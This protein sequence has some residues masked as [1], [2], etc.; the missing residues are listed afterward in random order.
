MLV[1]LDVQ[2]DRERNELYSA[3]RLP[4][5]AWG[6][7]ERDYT[8]DDRYA[9]AMAEL[10]N[11][12]DV[13]SSTSRRASQPGRR[14]AISRTIITSARSAIVAWRKRSRRR[15]AP[16]ARGS[17]WP[18]RPAQA[19]ATPPGD[20]YLEPDCQRSRSPRWLD[21]SHRM[22]RRTTHAAVVSPRPEER[23][24]AVVVLTSA[25]PSGPGCG[26]DMVLVRRWRELAR[27]ADV[28]AI[29]PTPWAP[30]ALARVSRR[31]AA[32][33]AIAPISQIDGLT[34][35]HPR[36]LQLPLPAFAPWAG[37]SMAAGALPLVRRLRQAGRCDVLFG[38]SVLPDGLAAA[39]A[40][41]WA[42]VPAACLGRGTDVNAIGRTSVAGRRLLRWTVRNSAAVGVVAHDLAATLDRL[43]EL[44][45]PTVLYDGIDLERFVPG[46][47][48]DARRMLGIAGEDPLVLFVG[49]LVR[50]KGLPQLVDAFA[51]VHAEKPAAR[52]AVVGE[53]PLRRDLAQRAARAG[54]DG[55]VDLVGEVPYERIP[56]WMQAAD[57]FT[58]PSEAEGFPNVVREALACDRPVVATAV[59]DIPRVV[60]PDVGRLVPVGD[61]VA[62]GDALLAALATR[63]D[64]GQPRAKVAQMTWQANAAATYEFLTAAVA[65]AR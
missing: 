36:Y 27:H 37:I 35:Y 41:R 48:A 10:A 8:H 40:G 47:R 4:Y 64:A 45:P 22:H 26:T 56:L 42:E 7:L 43:G 6:F 65:R 32:Y 14:K 59:G 58:L 24:L 5:P 11:V 28:V 62:L 15:C 18:A 39:L 13:A 38:Q 25:L 16:H 55:R 52:L 2:I 60:T 23:R 9:E 29:M 17:S 53:G 50:G 46:D 57:V 12:L 51:R 61:V 49:R 3:E 63:W 44:A 31:W 1:P 30:G 21:A 54:I 20:G 19:L 33:A 34:V